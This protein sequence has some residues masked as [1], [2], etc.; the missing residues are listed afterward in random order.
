[1]SD[2]TLSSRRATTPAGPRGRLVRLLPLLVVALLAV[3]TP[4]A[5]PPYLLN[6]ATLTVIVAVA[7][8]GLDLL[9]GYTGLESLG[10]AAFYG[11][12]AY[13]VGIL[14]VTH[15]WSWFAAA[16]AGIAL[17]L[18]L[19]ALF[20]LAAVRLGGL[21]FLLITLA[22]GQ[23]LWG[24]AQRWGSV[25]G[26]F[27]GLSGIPLPTTWLF[28][29]LH[30]YYA[31]LV[32]LVLAVA[33]ALLIV[34]SP[35]GLALRGCR[36]NEAK[37]RSM[38]YR[39]FWLKWLVF[40][41]AGGFAAVAG[42]M[43][44]TYN[45]FVSPSE[46]SL[47]LSFALMLM[48]IVG[49]GGHIYGAILGAAIVT[50]LQYGLS[51]YIEDHWLI[52]M[53]VVYIVTA[54]LIP[55][56][57]YG[58]RV[59]AALRRRPP[60]RDGGVEA[61]WQVRRPTAPDSRPGT[62]LELRDIGRRFG[63]FTALDGVSLEFATGERAAIIGPNGAGKTTLFQVISGMHRAS[64]GTVTVGG[65]DVT[66]R[67][68]H[69]RPDVGVARTF[70]IAQVFSPLT[71]LENML[72][73]VIAAS[74][75]RWHFTLWRPVPGDL[76]RHAVA[77]LERA[78]LGELLDVEVASLSYGHQKQLEIALAL[79]AEPSL[80]LLDEPTAG[81]SQT[82]AEEMMGLVESLPEGITVLIIE[83]N[84]DIVFRLT[85]RLVVLNHGRVLVDGPQAEVR[86]SDE[87]RR[88]YFGT[89]G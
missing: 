64:A 53:G 26:G 65:Y 10:Q 66:T 76:R 61:A 36:D 27:N 39:T 55:K 47:Q 70:Q 18:A 31:G 48:V 2:L 49:G 87:V 78:G 51:V 59:L 22:F 20:G 83:H 60:T 25:T 7:A 35:F 86:R 85:D 44:A 43:S 89:R 9:M 52:V 11:V 34:R 82:E 24:A 42:V 33:L 58:I 6:I 40:V 81:L 37:L 57:I 30:F 56:G 12:S 15:G 62:A 23:V 50:L 14:S 71:V 38:G 21:Y 46:L 74:P 45:S 79:V 41:I 67:P 8:V 68:A 17:S 77:Q 5:L 29:P 19:A 16:A 73:A 28:E 72:I 3:T 84:L 32:V 88:I 13:A 80:L 63:G 75:R 69:V 4:P 1:M 54:M